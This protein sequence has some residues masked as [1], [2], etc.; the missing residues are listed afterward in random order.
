MAAIIIS[1]TI[2]IPVTV[3]GVIVLRRT[4]AVGL[5]GYDFNEVVG[6]VQ[7]FSDVPV[8]GAVQEFSDVPVVGAVPVVAPVAAVVVVVVAAVV[9]AAVVAVV[10]RGCSVV[11]VGYIRD[12]VHH[13]VKF[14]GGGGGGGWGDRGCAC[15]GDRGQ[16]NPRV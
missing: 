3:G 10:V 13:G 5:Y 7:E 14:C 6:G 11:E 9:A 4:S 2:A 8:V 16:G 12:F 1:I 15:G